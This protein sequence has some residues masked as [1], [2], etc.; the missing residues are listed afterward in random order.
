M[1]NI[2]SLLALV[3]FSLSSVFS[4]KD[5]DDGLGAK[6]YFNGNA[7]DISSNINHG[8]VD[9]ALLTTDRFGNP[10]QAYSFDGIS[11]VIKTPLKTANWGDKL[12]I[13]AWVLRTKTSSGADFQGIISNDYFENRGIKM[14]AE[15]NTNLF[16]VNLN[17]S[18]L[19][20]ASFSAENDTITPA[21]WHF[22]AMIFD[23]SQLYAYQNGILKHNIPFTGNLHGDSTML[24]GRDVFTD[25]QGRYWG[26]KIDD[27]RIYNRALTSTEINTLYLEIAGTSTTENFSGNISIFPNPANNNITIETPSLTDVSTV[28]IY[29]IS[30]QLI[31]QQMIGLNNY[32]LDISKLAEGLYIVKVCTAKNIWVNKFEKE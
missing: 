6:Y 1:K 18:T 9:G 16:G 22:V 12:T 10:N 19:Q 23:G 7:N 25:N 17:N 2:I 24:I 8:L 15:P 20:N 11:N 28:S 26:G 32:N 27:I 21:I 4:Q 5:L 13:T 31:P 3:L 14:G 30:G 29:N